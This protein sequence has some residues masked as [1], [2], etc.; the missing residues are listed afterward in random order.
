MRILALA[1]I[2]LTAVSFAAEDKSIPSS[3]FSLGGIEIGLT[4]KEINR[5]LGKPLSR[6]RTHEG[7]K[8][9]YKGLD[10]YVGVGDYG[11]FDLVATGSAYC[12]P[13]RICPGTRVEKLFL[14]YGSTT[15]F[16]RETG[17]FLEYPSTD[18]T[19]WLQIRQS[20]GVIKSIRI[21]CQ[22]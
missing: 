10:A 4:E 7:I 19:C 6:S 3:E 15:E 22:P 16:A 12:T 5:A 17:R 13:S 18:S 11:L 9:S 1:L 21:A 8:L 14:T 2:T 20:K